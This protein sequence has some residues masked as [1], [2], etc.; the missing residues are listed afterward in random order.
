MLARMRMRG[1]LVAVLA[2]APGVAPRARAEERAPVERIDRMRVVGAPPLDARSPE[3][4]YVWLE[5][6]AFQLA[7]VAAP[8]AT[9]SFT[10]RVD[11]SDGLATELLGDFSVTARSGAGLV[12]RARVEG[13]PARG[14]VRTRGAVAV[15]AASAGGEPVPIFVGPLAVRGAPS[16]R[17]VRE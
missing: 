16:V 1:V 8:G 12:L 17:I 15:S 4:V 3:G 11:A 9:R 5:D 13:S 2:L 10:V 6:R 7:A 14:A